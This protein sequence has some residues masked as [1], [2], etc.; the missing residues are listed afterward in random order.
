MV[1][2]GVRWLERVGSSGV[3]RRVTN[4][5]PSGGD[6]LYA[7]DLHV[8]RSAGRVVWCQ[9][10]VPARTPPAEG[11]AAAR[12]AGDYLITNVLARRSSWLGCILDVRQG[13]SVFG[14][15]TRG[16]TVQLLDSA[17][18]ARKPFAVLTVGTGAQHDQ[19][20]TLAAQHAPRFGL[21]TADAQQ[22]SDWMTT[23]H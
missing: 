11:A 13:P 7:D 3:A 15:I 22:A 2:D 6:E 4:A 20:S 23:Q 19:Y 9:V 14:P 16:V 10:S 21:V 17:E 5:N 8:V 12:R 18:A 1:H